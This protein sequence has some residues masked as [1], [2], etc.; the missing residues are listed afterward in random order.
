VTGFDLGFKAQAEAW[1]D[2]TA[3]TWA[4]LD[5]AWSSAH[6]TYSSRLRAGYRLWPELSIGLEA[7]A[8]GNA[9]YDGGRGGAFL[10]YTWEGGEVSTSAGAAVDR[11]L[12]VGAYATFNVLFRF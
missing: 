4:S 7:G 2:L 6:D 9:E 10:R 1:L 12:D 5:V 11:S 3:S 8:L